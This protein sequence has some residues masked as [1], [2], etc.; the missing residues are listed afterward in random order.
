MHEIMLK[1][2]RHRVQND[3]KQNS[4]QRSELLLDLN[5]TMGLLNISYI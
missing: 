3:V 5:F 1:Y 2:G 4:Q